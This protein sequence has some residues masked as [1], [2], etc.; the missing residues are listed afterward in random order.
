MKNSNPSHRSLAMIMTFVAVFAPMIF[1]KPTEQKVLPQI[2]FLNSPAAIDR[3]SE[4][5]P[6]LPTAPG[7]GGPID[8]LINPDLTFGEEEE[9]IIPEP[10]PVIIKRANKLN[11][12]N[13]VWP[14]EN[15]VVS[16][17]FGWREPPCDECSSDHGGTDF[18]PGRGVEVVAVLDGLVI[19]AGIL[20]G[21]G[22]WVKLEHRVPSIENP[23]EFEVWETVYAHLQEDSIPRNVGVGS[24]IQKGSRLG[25]VGSTG[26]STGDHLHFEIRVNGEQKDPLPL[27][28]TYQWIEKMN[29]GSE[30]FVRYE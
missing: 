28:A 6:V 30:E 27:L 7:M 17:D 9:E 5:D 12:A 25:L 2:S 16:S 14:V 11:Y 29:D 21:Y 4:S 8:Q 10:E 23:G 26:V 19:E 24:I 1:A 22:T 18:A 3:I 13:A 15:P 20:G